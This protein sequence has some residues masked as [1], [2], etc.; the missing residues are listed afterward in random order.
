MKRRFAIIVTLL[1]FLETNL[2]FI[3]NIKAEGFSE[4]APGVGSLSCGS[5]TCFSLGIDYFKSDSLPNGT[6]TFGIRVQLVDK[7]NNIKSKALNIWATDGMYERINRV[8][9]KLYSVEDKYFPEYK[10]LFN[11]TGLRSLSDSGYTYS[12]YINAIDEDTTLKIINMLLDTNYNKNNLPSEY[13]DYY[14][15]VEPIYLEILKSGGKYYPMAGTSLEILKYAYYEYNPSGAN[16]DLNGVPVVRWLLEGDVKT[17]RNY[18]LTTYI[19]ADT[20]PSGTSFKTAATGINFETATSKEII[21]YYVCGSK[22]YCA[23][24]NK[25][26]GNNGLGVGYVTISSKIDKPCNGCS[27]DFDN[28]SNKNDMS[29][30]ISLYRKYKDKGE[31]YNQ[32]LN[33]NMQTSS[34]ACQ[35]KS[36]NIEICSGCLS[37]TV[38]YN[39]EFNSRN[40]SCYNEVRDGLY[41]FNSFELSNSLSSNSFSINQGGVLLKDVSITGVLTTSCY[42]GYA[43]SPFN[44]SDYIKALNIE[45]VSN[46]K[47]LSTGNITKSETSKDNLYTTKLTTNYKLP[48]VYASILS[49]KASY[50][51]CDNCRF[52]GYGIITKFIEEN[53]TF[54]GTF[55]SKLKIDKGKFNVNTGTLS[56]DCTYYSNPE[57]IDSGGLNLEFRIID[58]ENPFPGKSGN[59]NRK[60]G[61]N[62][63]DGDNCTQDNNSLINTYIKDANN[64]Y[65]KNKVA[66]PKYKITLSSADI[67]VIKKY[68]KK[69]ENYGGYDDNTLNCDSEYNCSSTFI[70]GLKSGILKY[71]INGNKNSE[72][73][74]GNMLNKII[75]NK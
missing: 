24:E 54:N 57:L 41:C 6:A 68:N 46:S 62:W 35:Y 48:S 1:L 67:E 29:A 7:N 42:G 60:V 21:N 19:T 51:K 69:A 20:K 49:G 9:T 15:K 50:N 2:F 22:S 59:N 71:Y 30:R 17:V 56:G 36:C 31:D 18:I 73:Y 74:I 23:Y 34:T 58:T 44:Y 70:E 65:N 33:L 32:L 52:L 5:S 75:I 37:S 61:L 47:K 11:Y 63:C 27:C 3:K 38:G 53:G 66:S 39:T 45:N 64:S 8:A 40:L 4:G 43:N 16:Y 55:S 28:L 13:F 25:R 10:Y 12:D 14:I 26:T 72:E